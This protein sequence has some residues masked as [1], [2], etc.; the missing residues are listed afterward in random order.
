MNPTLLISVAAFVGVAALVGGIAM[1]WREKS[2][3]GIE[4]RLDVL[5][6][7]STASSVKENLLKGS[8]LA[9]PLNATPS[10]LEGIVAHYRHLGLLFEQ[11]DTTLTPSRF[12][13]L[14]GLGR[15]GA[16][17]SMI[18]GFPA[19]FTPVGALAMATLPLLWLMFRR[20]KRMKAFAVQLPDALELTARA[21]ARGTAWRP[22]STWSARKWRHR[23]ARSLAASSRNRI[24]ASRWTIR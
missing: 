18:A 15:D 20:S 8:V 17:A 16:V 4:Q 19:P 3:K 21:L 13:D 12:R 14:G 2:D 6:G 24:S 7:V 1:L 9:A 23:S 5:T 22:D 10:I 11:A